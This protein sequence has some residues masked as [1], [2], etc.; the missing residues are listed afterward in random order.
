M[1]KLTSVWDMVNEDLKEQIKAQMMTL[2]GLLSYLEERSEIG[3]SEYLYC[4]AKLNE[5]VKDLK[6]LERVTDVDHP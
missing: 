1:A 2:Q 4:Q 5:V 6:R 3:A